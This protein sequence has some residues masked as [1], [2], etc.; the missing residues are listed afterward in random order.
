[1]FEEYISN[2]ENALQGMNLGEYDME[3]TNIESIK[4]AL[5][6]DALQEE[7]INVNLNLLNVPYVEF[8]IP[9]MVHSKNEIPAFKELTEG[10]EFADHKESTK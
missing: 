7:L 8:R 3:I 2:T 1:M 10:T 5:V 6:E 9:G 4:R